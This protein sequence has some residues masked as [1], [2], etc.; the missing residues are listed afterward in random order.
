MLSF[1]TRMRSRLFYLVF[2]GACLI[3]PSANAQVKQ[4]ISDNKSTQDLEYGLV[5]FDYFQ[6]NYFEALIE[7]EYAQS[8][9]NS[10]AKGSTGQILKGGMMLSYGMPDA[11]KKI[12]ENLLQSQAA[13][14]IRNKAWFYLAK[15]LYAKSDIANARDALNRIQGK[16]PDEIYTEYNYLVLL[17]AKGNLQGGTALVSEDIL[18]SAQKNTP[19]YPYLLF[20]TAIM[21]LRNNQLK[22]A[23]KNLE[24]VTELSGKS[25]ELSV[26]ADRARH[27]LAELAIKYNR[28]DEAWN[29]LKPIR[30]NGL[31]SNRALLS[32]AWAA[33]NLKRFNDAIPA[34]E[35]LNSR[36]IAIPEVQESIVLVAHVYEQEGLLKKA[37]QANVNAEKNYQKGVEMLTEARAIIDKQD[38]PREFISNIEAMIDDS[39]WFNTK[40]S[41]DYKKLTPFL[42]DL[43]AGYQF[44]ETLD[45]LADLYA[46]EAN[47]EY[48]SLQ[49]EQHALILKNAREKTYD[50]SIKELIDRGLVLKDQLAEKNAE[51]KLYT[52]SLSERE[53]DRLNAL[54]QSTDV[55][56]GF[57]NDK[58]EKLQLYK[59][60]YKQ[61]VEYDRMVADHHA[62]I[63]QRLVE[64][65]QFINR[66]EQIMRNLV[67]A[68]LDE[69][70]KRMKFYAAQSKLAKAR[71]Y[72]L[73]LLNL[74]RPKTTTNS[75]VPES[76]VNE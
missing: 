18:K 67:K 39:D 61:P 4:F 31:Y 41:V 9:D 3:A 63:K 62:M 43:M 71:L 44:R 14:E 64:I 65:R 1:T 11:S 7:Q 32:Y 40:P 70:E 33:I 8:I 13:E 66:F 75:K 2:G 54:S 36:S 35:M 52:L 15:M 50:N 20:N 57:L 29:Y 73:M 42:I 53:Q 37:L 76:K 26:L 58:I 55:E 5:L 16:V 30:T 74:E 46:M 69:H 56:L 38:V 48:W 22:D 12:F 34:L 23:V 49:A 19:Y 47:L 72:D 51:L 21:Q 59:M 10:I 28:L 24:A 6:K 68:E 45:E 17:I 27:G 60:P 25:E